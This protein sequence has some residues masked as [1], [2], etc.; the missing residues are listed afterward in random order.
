[1]TGEMTE[2]VNAEKNT[3]KPSLL[4]K[5]LT[6][7]SSCNLPENTE[8]DIISKFLLIIRSCVFSMTL[9]SGIIGGLL[10]LSLTKQISWLNWILSTIGIVIAHA[11]NNIINDFFDLKQGIDDDEYARAMYAPHPILT[12]LISKR[13][14]ILLALALN[15]IDVGILIYFILTVNWYV[16]FFALAGIFISVFYV[17]PPLNLKKHGLGEPAVF[18]IWGP[19]MIGGTFYVSTLGQISHWVWIATIPYALIVTT[20]LFGKHID[21]YE[22]DKK[23][24]IK[25]LPVIIGEKNARITN[26]VLMGLFYIIIII[27]IALKYQGIGLVLTFISIP[28]YIFVAKNYLKPKPKEPP[29]EWPIWPLWYVGFAFHLIRLSGLTLIFGLLANIFIPAQYLWFW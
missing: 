24:G 23:K 22:P 1:M 15:L 17:A 26:I 27:L 18:I 16:L 5:W 21:K 10:A 8:M 14:F 9:M 7:L 20:I 2:E 3:K 25:T 19:L 13:K 28:R 12:G 11:V 6:I 4:K 29:E